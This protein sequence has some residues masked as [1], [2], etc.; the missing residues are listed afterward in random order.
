MLRP[1]RSLLGPFLVFS[2][3]AA[4]V[5]AVL[6]FSGV[7]PTFTESR[8]D[9]NDYGPAELDFEFQKFS[10][11]EN[12]RLD[13]QAAA[14]PAFLRSCER[15]DA[16][17]DRAPANSQEALGARFEGVSLGG[18]A[19]DWRAACAGARD[20]AARSYGDEAARGDAARAFFEQHFRPV[21]IIGVRSPK[22]E[23]RALFR[24]AL[25]SDKGLFTGYF[26]PVYQASAAPTEKFSAP[27]LARPDN[28]VMVELGD[29]RKELAGQRIAGFIANG[30]LV[31]YADH[32]SINAGALGADALALA[33]LD[34]N[35]LFFMQVQGSG[36]LKFD[37]GREMRV[38]Y[39][40]QNGHPYTAI[41]KTLIDRG[42]MTLE[43]VSM[44]AIR[45]WLVTATPD[46]ARD[47]RESNPSYVFFREV[48]DLP[49]P[50]LGPLGAQ[51]AQLTDGRSLAV[52]RR[53]HALGAPVW[54]SIPAVEGESSALM[55]LF[56]AQDS[57]G[58]IRGPVRGDIYFGAGPEA[59][60]IAGGFRSEGRMSVLLPT[61]V[62]ARL[63][64]A[65]A[66]AER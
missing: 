64:M 57:G 12:W 35:D 40:G 30:R 65:R 45:N 5:A 59:A 6:V 11:I 9:E 61:P 4:A 41:G 17:P 18:T 55:R 31:P 8:I 24:K 43:D 1:R 49:N 7:L 32:R 38:G 13:D 3:A 26:E 47:V 22:A 23:G 20:V 21:R 58:A 44:Q 16:M 42:A 62:A 14:I 15:L 66:L 19:G 27:V 36:R 34:P 63:A 25:V 39:D 37:D 51:G 50:A 54:V 46:A 52:D 29:F 53:Y 48:T 28:L 33:W 56:I 2:V 10:E 60:E